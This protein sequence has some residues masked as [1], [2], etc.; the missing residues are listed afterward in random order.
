MG[1]AIPL[2]SRAT[3]LVSA[4]DTAKGGLPE[5]LSEKLHP[6]R[7]QPTANQPP[8]LSG[9]PSPPHAS[10]PP[11]RAQLSSTW[12]S[13]NHYCLKRLRTD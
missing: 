4:G 13:L 7:H 12:D 8:S 9:P 2:T 6:E 5:A 1:K 11:P 10:P 3:C